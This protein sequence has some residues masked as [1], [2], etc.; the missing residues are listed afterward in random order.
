MAPEPDRSPVAAEELERL[1]AAVAERLPAYVEELTSLVG[2]DTGSGDLA[3]LER[4]A[5]RIA[6]RLTALGASVEIERDP[7]H[8]PTVVGRIA[9][10]AGAPRILCIGH[11]DTVYP[12]G[13]AAARPLELRDGRILGPGVRTTLLAGLLLAVARDARFAPAEMGSAG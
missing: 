3:G 10:P 6:D 11:L 13:T 8:G 12:P 2:I 1:R 9:G 7:R 4:A 5:G